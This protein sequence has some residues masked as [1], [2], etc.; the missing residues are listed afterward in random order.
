[1]KKVFLLMSVLVGILVAVSSC[2]QPQPAEV[3]H[4]QENHEEASFRVEVSRWGF[5]NTPGEFRLEVEE[6][7]EVVITF[8]YGDDDLSQNNPHII[9]IPT[10]GISTATLDTENP[11]DTVSFTASRGGEVSFMCTLYCVGHANLRRG[12]IVIQPGR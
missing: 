3:P 8:V 11:E 4:P 12:S 7:Q 10:Y 5:N 9:T 6:G 1:M 2:T